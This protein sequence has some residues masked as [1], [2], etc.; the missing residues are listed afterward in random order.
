MYREV[1]IIL[2]ERPQFFFVDNVLIPI[3]VEERDRDLFP[4][5]VEIF[6]DRSERSNA[7]AARDENVFFREVFN[8]KITA[9]VRYLY[10]ISNFEIRKRL[11]ERASLVIR[12]TRRDHDRFFG[13]SR[14]DRKPAIRTAVIGR[15]MMQYIMEKLARFPH[16]RFGG[17]ENKRLNARNLV[18]PVF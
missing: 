1:W 18:F 15:F 14:G 13:G 16:N 10:R 12:K 17:F 2:C 4:A 5:L 7:N 11:F 8:R 9:Q 3:G 6:K